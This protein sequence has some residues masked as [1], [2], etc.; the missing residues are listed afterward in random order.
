MYTHEFKMTYDNV[1]EVVIMTCVVRKNEW[2][3]VGFGVNMNG[4]GAIIF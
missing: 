1:N 3:S 4:A 2:F